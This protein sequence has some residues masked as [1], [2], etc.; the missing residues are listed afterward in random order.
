ME[1][2]DAATDAPLES[3]GDSNA[4]QVPMG[5]EVKVVATPDDGWR[6]DGIGVEA[7][8][9]LT[10]LDLDN[11]VFTVETDGM[12]VVATFVQQHEVTFDAEGD[13]G[14]LVVSAGDVQLASGDVVDDGTLLTVEVVPD[15]GFVLE[16]L[17]VNGDDADVVDGRYEFTVDDDVVI[18]AKFGANG[19]DAV[20]AVGVHYDGAGQCLVAGSE[21][22]MSVFALDGSQVA[23]GS[24]MR[25]DLGA[26]DGGIYVARVVAVDG[27]LVTI[28]FQKR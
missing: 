22:A 11:P 20:A 3:E 27:T 7:S 14:S 13:G 8:D 25:L 6:L 17:R 26:L 12:T 10:E 9:E 18:E 28:K 1:L 24:G 15:D 2:V 19:L 16:W 21:C 5:T 4:F 23:S